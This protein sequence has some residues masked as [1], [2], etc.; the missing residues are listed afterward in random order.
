VTGWRST[1]DE[2]GKEAD[3]GQR[4]SHHTGCKDMREKERR[5]HV[6]TQTSPVLSS[7]A[8]DSTSSSCSAPA[9]SQKLSSSLA[10]PPPGLTKTH[11]LT[12]PSSCSQMIIARSDTVQLLLQFLR[13]GSTEVY[14]RE[15]NLYLDDV[16]ELGVDW[17]VG[18]LEADRKGRARA[19][20]RDVGIG[21][22]GELVEGR[23]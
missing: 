21:R 4:F 7:P 10:S 1:V 3:M 8:A 19:A 16:A 15:G 13:S 6:L 9:T 17:R 5:G 12:S 18:A 14:T 23:V 20:L 22:S 11:S 2:E